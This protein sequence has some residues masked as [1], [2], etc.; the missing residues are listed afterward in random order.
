MRYFFVAFL[1]MFLSACAAGGPLYTEGAHSAQ[2]DPDKSRVFMYRV[3]QFKLSGVI[4]TILDNGEDIGS[5]TNGGYITYLADPGTHYIHSST[6]ARD[7]PLTM[8]FEAGKTY[9]IRMK[10]IGGVWNIG[11]EA[12][13]MLERDALPEISQTRYQER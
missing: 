13:P 9:Y 5:I 6:T 11:L 3:K 4:A 7:E 8:E 1:L 10:V 2:V 12:T